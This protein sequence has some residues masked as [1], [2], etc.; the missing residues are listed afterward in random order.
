[1]PRSRQTSDGIDGT[2]VGEMSSLLL[3]DP[4]E[5]PDGLVLL[6]ADTRGGKPELLGDFRHRMPFAPQLQDP[7]LRP[8]ELLAAPFEELTVGQM[9]NDSTRLAVGVVRE[10]IQRN[11]RAV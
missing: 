6:I 10:L 11:R 8:A 4:P 7:T 1:L 5:R 9:I 3:H 2:R